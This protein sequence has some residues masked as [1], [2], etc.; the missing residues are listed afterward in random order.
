MLLGPGDPSGEDIYPPFPEDCPV[1]LLNFRSLQDVVAASTRIKI[2]G[3]SYYK[4]EQINMAHIHYKKALRYLNKYQDLTGEPSPSD[5]A[6]LT[7]AVLPNL[8]NSA[9]CKIKLKMYDQALEEC[10]EILDASPNNPKA[11]YR[12]GQAY[13]GKGDYDRAIKDLTT[14]NKL[15]P[16]DPSVM[17]EL[18]ACRGEMATY[19]AREK[20]ASVKYFSQL[21][22]K[23]P[24]GQSSQQQMKANIQKQP[25][26]AH[27]ASPAS[28]NGSSNSSTTVDAASSDRA[29]PSGYQPKQTTKK[30]SS[31]NESDEMMT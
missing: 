16:G 17:A 19:C 15:V 7:Q 31:S 26:A 1:S 3:N 11:Y 25:Q 13:H 23:S 2:V 9:A 27:Q 28:A 22:N 30:R 21:E 10:N 29:G 12:R 20:K 8:L 5:E 6:T 14:A 24:Q 4:K 18:K